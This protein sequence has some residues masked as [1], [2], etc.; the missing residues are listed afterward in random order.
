M[1][2]SSACQGTNHNR[3]TSWPSYVEL[4]IMADKQRR[5]VYPS[6]TEVGAWCLAFRKE[7]LKVG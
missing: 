5:C 4:D 3:A 6:E 1:R 2:Y 7:S